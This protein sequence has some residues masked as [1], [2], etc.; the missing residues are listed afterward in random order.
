MLLRR[1]SLVAFLVIA[2]AIAAP[3]SAAKSSWFDGTWQDLA[4][5]FGA[6]TQGCIPSDGGCGVDPPR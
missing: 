3:A 5:W 2:A 4:A 6:A 1:T